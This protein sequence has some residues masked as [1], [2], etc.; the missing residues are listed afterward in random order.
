MAAIKE[1]VKQPG[2]PDTIVKIEEKSTLW[3]M[4][5][6]QGNDPKK[7]KIFSFIGSLADA[8]IRAQIHCTAM[9]FIFNFVK[10]FISD[11]DWEEDRR[12]NT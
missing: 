11:L 9:G 2:L 8:R 10:P 3:I 4:Y 5:F 7:E 12:K 6:R 1:E